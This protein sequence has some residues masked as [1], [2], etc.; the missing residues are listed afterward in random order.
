[1]GLGEARYGFIQIYKSYIEERRL[2]YL[3]MEIILEISLMLMILLMG[4]KILD[5]PAFANHEWDSKNPDPSTSKAP[6]CIYNIEIA[7]L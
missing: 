4:I 1:M 2:I 7:I 3:I 5:K 6:W